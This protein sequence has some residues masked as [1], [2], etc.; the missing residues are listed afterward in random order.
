M[1]TSHEVERGRK[2][3]NTDKIVKIDVLLRNLLVGA[4]SC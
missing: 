2:R 4:G 1:L 3:M